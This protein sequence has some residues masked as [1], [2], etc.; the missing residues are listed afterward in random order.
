MQRRYGVVTLWAADV[1]A[2]GVL[3]LRVLFLRVLV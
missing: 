3:G 1:H 2:P